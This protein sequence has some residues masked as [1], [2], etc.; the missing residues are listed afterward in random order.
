[1]FG[2]GKKQETVIA[3]KGQPVQAAAQHEKLHGPQELPMPVGRDLVVQLKQDPDYVW[4]LQCVMRP[5]AANKK[6]F[7]VRIFSPNTAAQ[8]R[9]RVKDYYS[10]D[11]H[12]ELI[13]FQ[14]TYDKPNSETIL[15]AAA[16]K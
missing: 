15:V 8:S 12:P 9:V 6:I 4:G 10:L 3:E 14:G 11:D 7:D 2:F 1:M 16:K 13:L 5:D